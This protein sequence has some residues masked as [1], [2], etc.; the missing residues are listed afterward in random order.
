MA[1]NDPLRNFRF[2]LEIDGI[3]QADFSEVAIGETTTDAIDYREGTDPMHV[4][5]LSGLTKFGNVTLKW[6]DHRL[7]WSS[8]TGTSRSSAGQIQSNRKQVAIVVV[9]RGRQ[10]TRRASSSA[11]LAD[12]VRPER[13]QRQR[14]R[15]LHRAARA[16]NEGIERVAV[17][18]SRRPC[19]CQ[20]IR[21]FRPKSTS[22]C[23]RAISTTHGVLHR[24]GVMRLATAADEILPLRDPRVQQNQAYLAIIVL[25]RVITQARRRCRTSTRSVI[26]GLFASDLDY[27][28]RLYERING[29]EDEDDE[30]AGCRATARAAVRIPHRGGSL[31][32]YP[33]TQLHE[34]MAFIAYHFHWAHEELMLLEHAERR[35]WC[36]EISRSI[37]SSTARRRTRSRSVEAPAWRSATIRFAAFASGS[38]S[39]RSSTAA[40]RA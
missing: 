12:Q 35:R 10:P 29:G 20:H 2:R 5:K 38:S 19:T 8:T 37:A 17:T 23:R 1:R 26:E 36:R 25:A 31:K 39:T 3:T 14:Q 15:G 18:R 34:E 16:V 30:P 4:R 13:P 7:D 28:Q 21:G 9:R 11:S 24:R 40:S 32:A 33:A 22:R 6:G 27:L